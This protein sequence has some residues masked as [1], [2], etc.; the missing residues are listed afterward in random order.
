[1]ALKDTFFISHGS[2]TI[3]I[4][5]SIPAW[6]FLTSWKE[7]LPQRFSSILVIS[8]HWDTDVPTVNV[9]DHNKTIYDYY[10]FPKVMYKCA[11]SQFH[12]RDGTYHYNL[13]KV[14]APLKDQDVLIIRSGSALHN[15]RA[16]G[17]RNSPTAP[18]ALAFDSWLKNSLI[19]GRY[20]EVNKFDEKAPYAK[21]AHPWPDHFFPLHVAMGAAGENSK[22][23][24][25]HHS[26][27]AGSISCA[28]FGFTAATS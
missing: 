16:I 1:M 25:V 12:H 4:D 26:W 18:W 19:E 28:S 23:K 21:L 5:D 8:G 20:E 27:D 3:S 22:A 13:G 14:L 6:E 11:S 15:L 9:V 10:G 17:P 7:V 2:S 24:I